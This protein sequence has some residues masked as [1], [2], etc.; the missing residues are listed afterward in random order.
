[1]LGWRCTLATREEPRRADAIREPVLVELLATRCAPAEP[2]PPVTA[3]DAAAGAPPV[4][5]QEIVLSF[6]G[7]DDRPNP[8]NP[9]SLSPTPIGFITEKP[10]GAARGTVGGAFFSWPWPRRP[11]RILMVGSSEGIQKRAGPCLLF[12]L[13]RAHRPLARKHGEGGGEKE[14]RHRGEGRR[15]RSA[16]MWLLGCALVAICSAARLSAAV[17]AEV[18]PVQPPELR[19]LPPVQAVYQWDDAN[20]NHERAAKLIAWAEAENRPAEV[21][22]SPVRRTPQVPAPPLFLRQP[23]GGAPPSASLACLRW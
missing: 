3:A 16:G 12:F 7:G 18:P 13:I 2:R 19:S 1:M 17:S 15:G 6:C 10:S 4:A 20:G 11:N 5:V 23:P 22:V 9:S 8:L 21:D 14:E